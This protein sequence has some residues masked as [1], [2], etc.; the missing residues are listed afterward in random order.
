MIIK[1]EIGVR[2]EINIEIDRR[3]KENVWYEV[4]KRRKNQ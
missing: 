3:Y 2:E 4:Q 1:K